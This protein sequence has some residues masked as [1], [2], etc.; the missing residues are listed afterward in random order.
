MTIIDFMVITLLITIGA[1]F[2]I[3]ACNYGE[4]GPMHWG[5]KRPQNDKEE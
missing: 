3:A 4:E 1:I 5:I 2:Y